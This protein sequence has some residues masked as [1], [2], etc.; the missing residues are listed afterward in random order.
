MLAPALILVSLHVI[1]CRYAEYQKAD[2]KGSFCMF[3]YVILR[4]YKKLQNE[5][6]FLKK[7]QNRY[8]NEIV[9]HMYKLTKTDHNYDQFFS[10]SKIK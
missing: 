4:R 2:N 8:K 6:H 9:Y 1:A 10:L 7:L 3:L 5:L